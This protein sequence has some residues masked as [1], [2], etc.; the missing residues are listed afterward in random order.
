ML[1]QRRRQWNNIKPTLYIL[2]WVVC[3]YV[4]IIHQYIRPQSR[5]LQ[6]ALLYMYCIMYRAHDNEK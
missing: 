5:S 2:Y 4:T 6:I 3:S 1:G